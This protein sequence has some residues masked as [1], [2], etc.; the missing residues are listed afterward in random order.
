MLAIARERES[1]EIALA[2]RLVFAQTVVGKIAQLIIAQVEN[3]DRL[4]RA[5][6]FVPYPWLSSAA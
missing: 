5:S 6:F 2:C 1:D 4:T 3:R